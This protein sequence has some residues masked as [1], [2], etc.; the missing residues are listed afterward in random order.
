[1]KNSQ[2]QFS[3][4][5]RWP[6]SVGPMVGA[7]VTIR[8]TTMLAVSRRSG[9]KTVMAVAKIG[10]IIAPAASPCSARVKIIMST[11]VER[12][13]ATEVMMKAM[14]ATT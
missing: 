2:R 3:A 12:P 4:S 6:P 8:P 13:V 9:G 10:G 14:E 5:V 7:S 11:L 1:M